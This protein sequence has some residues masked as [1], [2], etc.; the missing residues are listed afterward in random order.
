MKDGITIC[1]DQ[2][3]TN[4]PQVL[5]VMMFTRADRRTGGHMAVGGEPE[6]LLRHKECWLS[7]T[8]PPPPAL[9]T[10]L[11]SPDY[12]HA[13]SSPV[14]SR[15]WRLSTSCYGVLPSKSKCHQNVGVKWVDMSHHV[16]VSKPREAVFERCGHSF[17]CDLS[18]R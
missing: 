9:I 4:I 6:G 11:A 16:L 5:R 1:Y 10:L 7:V 12:T 14:R 8:P 17:I 13:P 15:F 18:H 3:T 2:M